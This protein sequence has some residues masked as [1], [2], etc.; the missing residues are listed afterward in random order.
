M[1]YFVPA[2]IIAQDI[3]AAK[4]GSEFP[5]QKVRSAGVS[6][7]LRCYALCTSNYVICLACDETFTF[8]HLKTYLSLLSD[9]L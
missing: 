5:H 7:M 3:K 4:E 6:D 9:V 1:I 8:E 2:R